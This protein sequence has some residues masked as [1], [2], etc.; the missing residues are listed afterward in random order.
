MKLKQIAWRIVLA[1]LVI[2]L[3]RTAGVAGEQQSTGSAANV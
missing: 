2:A 1:L 3:F